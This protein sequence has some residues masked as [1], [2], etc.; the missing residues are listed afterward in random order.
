MDGFLLR[1][2]LLLTVI[3]LLPVLLIRAQPYDD[4]G[5]RAFLTPP[6]DCPAPC[7]MGIRPGVTT[8][9]EAIAILEE[10][11]WV[12]WDTESQLSIGPL[13]W[14]W[15]VQAPS[16]FD[17]QDSGV[18]RV[19]NEQVTMLG[20][21]MKSSWADLMLALGRPDNYCL[22]MSAEMSS[23]PQRLGFDYAAWYGDLGLKVYATGLF[24]GIDLFNYSSVALEFLDQPPE[25]V[26]DLH[27][28]I[29]NCR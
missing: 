12:L 1:V 2:A 9:E 3:F 16:W 25:F 21:P 13:I 19:R 17:S 18:V 11:P 10:Q 7:F 8:A 20:I 26:S 24:S 5:L 23:Q 14:N 29:I 6:E 15:S 22:R 27:V 4:G 28:P